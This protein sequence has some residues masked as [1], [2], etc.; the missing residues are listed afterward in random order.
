MSA[1]WKRDNKVA[2]VLPTTQAAVRGVV[3]AHAGKMMELW[4][5]PEPRFSGSPAEGVFSVT[6]GTATKLLDS[7]SRSRFIHGCREIE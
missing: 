7:C 1:K 5:P 6:G 4:G 3:L 2:T